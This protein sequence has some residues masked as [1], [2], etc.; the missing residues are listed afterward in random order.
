MEVFIFDTA[1]QLVK[2]ID[3]YESFIWT[4]RY[5]EYGDFEL[6][7]PIDSDIVQ[8]LKTDYY[9]EIRESNRTMIIEEIQINTDIDNGP[10][11]KVSGRSLESI[12]DRRI[13][14][15]QST[16]SGKLNDVVRKILYEN[17]MAGAGA[18]RCIDIFEYVDTDDEYISSIT[19]PQIQ[20]TGDNL[21]DVI[22]SICDAFEIG[23]RIT[24]GEAEERDTGLTY[25]YFELYAGTNRSYEN[26]D[27]TEQFKN[28]H[29]V[30]SPTFDNLLD[31]SYF[32]SNKALKTVTL[33]AGAGEGPDRVKVEVPSS[34]GAGT[35]LSRRELFTDARDLTQESQQ[36]DENGNITTV[37]LTPEEYNAAL[38]ERGNEKLAECT[39][40]N[41]FEGGVDPGIEY[42]Y[43]S[44]HD[45]K[46]GDADYCIGDIVQVENEYGMGFRCRV[47]E[48]IR[49]FDSSG[50]MTYPTFTKI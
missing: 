10:S 37:T 7:L 3:S 14:W 24:T 22:K 6:Y 31:S 49:S 26:D 30:F 47:S 18:E 20:F 16:F 12:L 32:E 38:T 33:V 17:I 39:V 43:G 21:Y 11:L 1:F 19:V 48:F 4:E 9:V 5:S 35:G 34:S 13:I 41:S 36:Q 46:M 45:V 8:Y 28:P 29:V 50:S 27:G 2:I 42:K 23:F 25:F 40:I 44:E 15:N